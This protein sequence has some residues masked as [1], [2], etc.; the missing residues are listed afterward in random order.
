[1][2][3]KICQRYICKQRRVL[4]KTHDVLS[5]SYRNYRDSYII[6]HIYLYYMLY[7]RFNW[8]ILGEK[9]VSCQNLCSNLCIC[10]IFMFKPTKPQIQE[11]GKERER[12]KELRGRREGEHCLDFYTKLYV[13]A[14]TLVG[15][16]E[17]F[18]KTFFSKKKKWL[19]SVPHKEPCTCMFLSFTNEELTMLEY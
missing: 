11:G 14:K 16:L 5:F 10:Y 4:V 15:T 2:Y 12:E 7:S 17:K 8:F 18:Q 19:R 1:M 9:L 3:F 13:L 6:Y